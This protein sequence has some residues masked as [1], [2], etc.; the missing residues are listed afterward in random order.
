M[1]KE[2]DF[3]DLLQEKEDAIAADEACDGAE[4]EAFLAHEEAVKAHEASTA[5]R[6]AAH[7]A[8]HDRLA[9]K[10]MHHTVDENGT[11]QIYTATDEGQGW[12]VDHPIPGTTKAAK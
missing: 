9:E 7:Q 3:I 5:R 2:P 8:I 1:P 12:R 11:V 6:A 10:G 4:N